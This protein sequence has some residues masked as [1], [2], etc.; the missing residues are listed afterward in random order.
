MLANT[1]ARHLCRETSSLNTSRRLDT[2]NFSHHGLQA[3]VRLSR[4]LQP[5][6]LSAR[7]PAG[8]SKE[9]LLR[10]YQWNPSWARSTVA[11]LALLVR[12]PM[13]APIRACLQRRRRMPSC[14]KARDAPVALVSCVG[15]ASCTYPSAQLK[16]RRCESGW[17]LGAAMLDW[18]LTGFVSMAAEVYAAC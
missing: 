11:L 3:T 2:V 1:V 18:Q 7:L 4:G 12:A 15:G 8:K 5:A 14:E 16:Y 13:L 17:P 6:L 9:N 10:Q